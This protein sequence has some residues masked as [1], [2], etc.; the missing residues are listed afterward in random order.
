MTHIT[1]SASMKS[2]LDSACEPLVLCDE[3]G[4]PLGTFTPVSRLT[5]HERIALTLPDHLRHSKVPVE[6]LRR[7]LREEPRIPHEEVMEQFRQY[8]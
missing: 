2:Q 8:L 6:E 5:E 4:T 1:I 3:A 7:R